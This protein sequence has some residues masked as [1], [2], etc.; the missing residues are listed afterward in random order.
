MEYK[1]ESF[2]KTLNENLGAL[3]ITTDVEIIT[4]RPTDETE[5]SREE[6]EALLDLVHRIEKATTSPIFKGVKVNLESGLGKVR[7]ALK[8]VLSKLDEQ[9]TESSEL[10]KGTE[11]ETDEHEDITH[12]D[13]TIG[14]K[15]AKAHLKKNPEYY[16]DLEDCD[17]E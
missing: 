11:E 16:S 14:K 8:R 1:F 5:C 10:E 17:I 12:G 6:V 15:I 13:K 3:P 9:V 4:D 7:R 2:I